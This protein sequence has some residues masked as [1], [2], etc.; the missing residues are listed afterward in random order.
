MV[1]RFLAES[2][3]VLEVITGPGSVWAGPHG[4]KPLDDQYGTRSDSR[5]AAVRNPTISGVQV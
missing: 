3:S 1:P 5:V 2:G 4:R